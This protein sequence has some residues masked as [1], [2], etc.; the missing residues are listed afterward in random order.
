[1]STHHEKA[2]D[3]PHVTELQALRAENADLKAKLAVHEPPPPP[4]VE[5]PAWRYQ[6]DAKGQI[7]AQALVADAAADA[8]LGKGWGD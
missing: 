7:T 5:Y 3:K 8:A 6:R 4:K 1:M 2:V